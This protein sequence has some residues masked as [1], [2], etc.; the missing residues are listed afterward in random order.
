V[1]KFFFFYLTDLD[2]TVWSRKK[3]FLGLRLKNG[4]IGRCHGSR[5]WRKKFFFH[6]TYFDLTGVHI[7]KKIKSSKLKKW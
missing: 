4:K 5:R 1:R 7:K 6:L 2:H 3:K